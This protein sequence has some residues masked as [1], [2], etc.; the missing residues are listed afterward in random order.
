MSRYHQPRPEIVLRRAEEL[1]G[2]GQP[3]S[4][5]ETLYDALMSKRLRNANAAST[6][7]FI[8]KF[9]ELCIE[10]RRGKQLKEGLTQYRNIVQHTNPES[11]GAVVEVM[12]VN[13]TERVTAAQRSAEQVTVDTIE[14]LDEAETPENMILS[15][16]SGEQNRDRADR[17]LVTPWLKFLW[18]AYR[19]LLDILRN[20]VRFEALYQ[21]ISNKAI[22]FCRTYE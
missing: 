15:L 10:Q 20:N 21:S 2:V 4:A 5:L 19:N 16:V 17:A 9:A 1:I 6:E 3:V 11:L 8:R 12:L 13:I 7:P 22:D 18:E 14:D